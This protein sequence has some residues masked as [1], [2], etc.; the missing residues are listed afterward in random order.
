M[1][2]QTSTDNS[3]N[4]CQHPS[5][6]K[7]PKI[8]MKKFSGDPTNLYGW[9]HLTHQFI[10]ILICMKYLVNPFMTEAVIKQK[11]DWFLYDNGL[12]HERVNE[13]EVS[14]KRSILLIFWL[15]K[16]KLQ[17]RDLHQ[18]IKIMIARD[19]LSEAFGD[20]QALISAHVSKFCL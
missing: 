2:N 13:D 14:R 1:V 11:L 9:S 8:E 6:V 10:L 12:R 17:L 16:Q 19:L 4:N 5:S 18:T 3:R 15:E 20:T 7:L